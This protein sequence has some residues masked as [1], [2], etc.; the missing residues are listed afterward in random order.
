[1]RPNHITRNFT[2]PKMHARSTPCR[3]WRV[4]VPSR[5]RAVR[6]AGPVAVCIAQLR[7]REREAVSFP[8]EYA[9]SAAPARHTHTRASA[10][11]GTEHTRAR[12][13]PMVHTLQPRSREQRNQTRQRNTKVQTV[14][15]VHVRRAFFLTRVLG[16]REKTLP[17]GLSNS[18]SHTPTKTN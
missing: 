1:M 6:G 4:R 17:T 5:A 2:P 10:Q 7:A 11:P 12:A 3:M 8:R 16:E 15:K 9:S 18:G 14:S 13:P